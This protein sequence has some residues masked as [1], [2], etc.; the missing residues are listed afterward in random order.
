MKTTNFHNLEC[1][2][3]ENEQVQIL[4]PKVL[5]PRILSLRFQGGENL[6]AE[7]PDFVTERPD[8]VTYHFHGGHRFWIAPE[9][10][11]RSYALD[12]GA[13]DI[14]PTETGLLV[15]KPVEEETGM[16]KS[17]LIHL[18][19][20]MASLTLVHTLTNRNSLPVEWAPWTI[21][22]LR[23]GGVAI[24][25]QTRA[26]TGLLPNRLLS[27]WSYADINSPRLRL[28]NQF[29]FLYAQAQKPIKI[30]FP[31]PRGWLAYWLAGT[32]FVKRAEFDPQGN[33]P[34]FGSSSEC[35]C[36]QSFLELETLAPMVRLDPDW[37]LHT[38]TPF[39]EDE[40]AMLAIMRQA[41]LE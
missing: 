37:E 18:D 16:E 6:L 39:P 27:L 11:I 34:D 5:G 41:G 20:R 21:T 3:L 25:P 22:Q 36:N 10:P 32:L 28:G 14:S 29:I 31:N 19:P 35:Y 30:G 13:V 8:G 26:H 23:S 2:I 1:V 40:L 24:L 9:D 33:Y 17:I 4:V 12:D 38:N 7:L 15:R